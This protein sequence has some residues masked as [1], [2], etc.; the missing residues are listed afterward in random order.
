M[1]MRDLSAKLMRHCANECKSHMTQRYFG[2]FPSCER[3]PSACNMKLSFGFASLLFIVCSGAFGGPLDASQLQRSKDSKLSP[4]E[5]A[6]L[7]W[8][9]DMHPSVT[10]RLYIAIYIRIFH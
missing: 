6:Q 9:A 3:A 8:P 10:D 5:K 2:G 7:S 1:R 4:G